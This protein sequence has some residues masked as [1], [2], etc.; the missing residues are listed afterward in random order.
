VPSVAAPFAL[1]AV[2]GVVAG[3]L[4]RAAALVT[5]RVIAGVVEEPPERLTSA[6]ASTPSA[7]ATTTASAAIRL[8]QLGDAARR[9]RAAAP[10]FRHHSWSGCNGAPHRGQASAA[11]TRAGAAAAGVAPPGG[12]EVATLMSPTPEDG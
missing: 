5:V 4:V 3:V 11:G 8:F 10:Q 6:A 1:V 2:V 12:G 9:V 7:S